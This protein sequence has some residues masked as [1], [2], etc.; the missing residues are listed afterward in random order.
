[1]NQPIPA[2]GPFN[3]AVDLLSRNLVDKADKVAF[4]DAEGAHTYAEVATRAARTGAAL[5]GLGLAP[6]DRI[7][8]VLQDSVD[9]VCAF[10]GAIRAGLIPIPLNTLFAADDYAYILTDSDARLAL[11]STPLLEAVQA[12]ITLSGWNGQVV[13]CGANGSDLDLAALVTRA[14]TPEAPHA[15]LGDDIAF[16][17]YSSGSTGR[18]KGTLH[19]HASLWHTAELYSRQVFGLR[20]TDVVFSAAKLFFAYGLG[21]G[22]TFPM[23]AGATCIL[24]AERITPEVAAGVI[25]DHQVSVFCG[26]PTLFGAMLAADQAPRPGKGPGKGALRLCMSAGEALPAALGSAWSQ[27]TGTEIVD[28][29]GST[30]MLHIFVSNR[31]GAVRYG[32]TGLP[33][34]GYEV[35]LVGEDG[36][37]VGPGEIGELHVRGPSMAA[38]YWNQPEKTAAT[39]IEG[40]VRTGDKFE[41][42]IE[43]LLYHRGRADDMLKVS[44]IW[45]SPGEVENALLA[46]PSVLE[47]AVIGVTDPSG[48]VKSKAFVVTRPGVDASPGLAAALT[49]FTKA[50][51]A[52]YKYPRQI[53]FVTELPKTATGKIRR[54]VLRE[55]E[56][57][58]AARG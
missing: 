55:L 41:I 52:A 4:I 32:A 40:W 27:V 24:M 53:A 13:T 51:L 49:A 7:V 34:P 35:R 33:T 5:R 14:A 19:R 10:L 45:V 11:V 16:W 56:A 38:G 42:D 9:F 21:N 6:G 29:I 31:P 30:E 1:M 50:R 20:D 54:H 37:E 36:A 8:L 57:A 18:P 28:G 26:V 39:F 47:A 46:H 2:S 58:K 43:G 17:L 12:A 23:H 44:G 48:L 3:A 25:R 22:L 15:S